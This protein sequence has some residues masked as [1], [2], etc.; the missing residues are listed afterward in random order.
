MPKKKEPCSNVTTRIPDRLIAWMD[1]HPE[2]NYTGLLI[3]AI[4]QEIE[5]KKNFGGLTAG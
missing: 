1:L 3:R 4:E 2:Y 5:Y